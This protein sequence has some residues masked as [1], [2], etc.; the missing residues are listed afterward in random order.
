MARFVLAIFFNLMQ[1]QCV[2]DV[3][4][5]DTRPLLGVHMRHARFV[6]KG[7]RENPETSFRFSQLPMLPKNTVVAKH[8]CAVYKCYARMDV[9]L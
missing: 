2:S 7:I 5:A 4:R 8:A 3:R 1:N 6:R 9:K